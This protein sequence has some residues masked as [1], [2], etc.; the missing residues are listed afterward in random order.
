MGITQCVR[1]AVKQNSRGRATVFG[2]RTRCWDEFEV[3]VARL[4]GGLQSLGV[5]PG[6]RVAMLALN[7]DRY[8]ETYVAVPWAGAVVVPLNTRWSPAENI[9]AINDSGARF[10]LVD[11]MFAALGMSIRS[12]SCCRIA[13]FGRARLPP[14]A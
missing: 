4:A 7:S 10:L 8:L 1:R 9:Y 14:I 3:R 2:E 6:E 13:R 12:E 11:D 5:R